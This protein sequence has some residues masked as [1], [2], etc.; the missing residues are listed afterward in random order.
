VTVTF[1][2]TNNPALQIG[3]LHCLLHLDTHSVDSCQ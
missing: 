3:S 2:G 1:D